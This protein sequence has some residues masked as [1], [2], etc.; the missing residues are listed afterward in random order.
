MD[1]G[2]PNVNIYQQRRARRFLVLFFSF[3][4]FNIFRSWLCAREKTNFSYGSA[5]QSCGSIGGAH[6]IDDKE[7]PRQ[8]EKT[9]IWNFNFAMRST[10][11][12]NELIKNF[13]NQKYDKMVRWKKYYSNRKLWWSDVSVL[14]FCAIRTLHSRLVGRFVFIGSRAR[15]YSVHLRTCLVRCVNVCTI[16]TIV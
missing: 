10:V 14:R 6:C 5:L 2:Y 1:C 15:Y 16:F 3:V 8:T 4:L 13:I 12:F 9:S 11:T 7:K